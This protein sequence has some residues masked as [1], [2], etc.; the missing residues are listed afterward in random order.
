MRPRSESPLPV[1]FFIGILLILYGFLIIGQ[2]MWELFVPPVR[3]VVLA[4][5]WPALWWGSL[6]MVIGGI[7]VGRFSPW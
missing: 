3:P 1:W 2:G 4:E 6:I 7:F 5:L